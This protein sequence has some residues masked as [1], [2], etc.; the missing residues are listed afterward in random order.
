MTDDPSLFGDESSGAAVPTHPQPSPIADW[1]RALIRK[2]LDS[3]GLTGMDERQK[4]VQ[5]AAGRPLASLRDLTHDEAI[6]LLT[7]LGPSVRAGDR[8]E[9]LWDS[10][11]EDT[12]I[13]KL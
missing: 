13:D 2:A 10:R 7:R 3:H 4:A 6:A 12:W 8:S 11:D 1:Q 9:S 5:V